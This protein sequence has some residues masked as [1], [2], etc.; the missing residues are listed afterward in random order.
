MSIKFKG[1][2]GISD[3]SW[4]FRFL[5]KPEETVEDF[6]K[7]HSDKNP[8]EES[9]AVAERYVPDLA[10]IYLMMPYDER[11]KVLQSLH[12]K[13]G[14]SHRHYTARTLM[15]LMLALPSLAEEEILYIAEWVDHLT[16][17]HQFA[18]IEKVFQHPSRDELIKTFIDKGHDFFIS[19][20][21]L[22]GSQEERDMAQHTILE[23]NYGGSL[24]VLK[25]AQASGLITAQAN[26]TELF[27]NHFRQANIHSETS[28]LLKKFKNEVK[29]AIEHNDPIFKAY[30]THFDEWCLAVNLLHQKDPV[31]ALTCFEK[32]FSNRITSRYSTHERADTL[33][34]FLNAG[35]VVYQSTTFLNELKTLFVKGDFFD[36]DYRITQNFTT[37]VARLFKYAPTRFWDDIRVSVST[38]DILFEDDDTQKRG[39]YNRN[40]PFVNALR[41]ISNRRHQLNINIPHQNKISTHH[42]LALMMSG[43]STK[44]ERDILKIGIDGDSPWN[45]I[46]PMLEDAPTE[47]EL[48]F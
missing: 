36:T 31:Q 9:F 10:A 26:E 1:K 48:Y 22:R 11:F 33:I 40:F 43:L 3:P 28:R 8:H 16:T 4:A 37:K 25:F 18:F 7:H 39:W 41:A 46:T 23:H 47:S 2:V 24:Q 32:G 38:Q 20:I 14:G 15:E 29:A 45:I 17:V 35:P 12:Q 13:K 19:Y 30:Q 42:A 21:L 6:Y 5:A 27:V 34:A 44:S